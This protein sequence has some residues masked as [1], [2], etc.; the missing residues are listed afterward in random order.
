MKIPYRAAKHVI[1]VIAAVDLDDEMQVIKAV[2]ESEEHITAV[3]QATFGVPEEDL[4]FVDT[5]EMVDLA[6]EIINYVLQK[7]VSIKGAA[8]PNPQTPATTA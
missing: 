2:L 3:V 5:M 1:N 8:G 6:R 4:P 7:V